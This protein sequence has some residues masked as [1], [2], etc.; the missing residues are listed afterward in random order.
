MAS[1]ESLVSGVMV[2]SVGGLF[3]TTGVAESVAG[4]VVVKASSFAKSSSRLAFCSLISL[5]GSI[6]FLRIDGIFS[7]SLLIF[8]LSLICVVISGSGGADFTAICSIG[9]VVLK[10]DIS[11]A[12][13]SEDSSFC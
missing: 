5:I 7:L 8:E 9:A 12:S 1:S 4:E 11:V 10:P 13:S 2:C 6:T 3:N